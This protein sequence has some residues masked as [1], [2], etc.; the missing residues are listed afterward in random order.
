MST[1]K[2]RMLSAL[3]AMAMAASW[4]GGVPAAAAGPETGETLYQ[5]GFEDPASIAAWTNPGSYAVENGVLRAENAGGALCL[6]TPEGVA[7]GDYIV[8]AKVTVDAIN[9]K[10]GSSAGLL[11]RAAGEK[12]FF[13]FRL[14]ASNMDGEDAQLYQNSGGSMAKLTETPFD[15]EAGITYTLTASA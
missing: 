2:K 5:N 15:W 10:D 7:G 6:S 9:M 12:D 11:F 3:L 8:S 13:H 1:R 14:N 4:L